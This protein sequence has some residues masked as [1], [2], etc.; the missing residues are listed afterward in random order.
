MGKMPISTHHHLM[1][2][3]DLVSALHLCFIKPNISGKRYENIQKKIKRGWPATMDYG[4]WSQDHAIEL[5][6]SQTRGLKR[7]K[8]Q[9]GTIKVAVPFKKYLLLKIN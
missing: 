9:W 4:L 8:F 2:R 7:L 5:D 1:S 3:K 6:F